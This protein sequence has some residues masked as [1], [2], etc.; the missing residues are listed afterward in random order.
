MV[1]LGFVWVASLAHLKAFGMLSRLLCVLGCV[2]STG[3]CILVGDLTHAWGLR[4]GRHSTPP[5]LVTMNFMN[6]W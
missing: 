6:P 4:S 3:W 1:D 2:R 5:Y